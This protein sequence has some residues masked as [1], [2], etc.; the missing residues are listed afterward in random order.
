VSPVNWVICSTPVVDGLPKKLVGQV[1]Q[2]V[3]H[4]SIVLALNSRSAA[5]SRVVEG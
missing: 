2:L 1:G 4:E 3:F 5:A